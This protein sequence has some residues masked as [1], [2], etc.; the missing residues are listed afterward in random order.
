MNKRA[1]QPVTAS[2]YELKSEP[3]N[4][5]S[6]ASNYST[7]AKKHDLLS[8][9]R[10]NSDHYQQRNPPY[11]QSIARHH[12]HSSNNGQTQFLQRNPQSFQAQQTSSTR[13]QQYGHGSHQQGTTDGTAWTTQ[14][15]SQ[16][17]RYQLSSLTEPPKPAGFSLAPGVPPAHANDRTSA[18]GTKV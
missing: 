9:Q 4:T 18:S 16:H 3:E 6:S 5:I 17:S 14:T 1:R 2:P 15:L 11:S 7:F 12:Q 8:H 10:N 13:P